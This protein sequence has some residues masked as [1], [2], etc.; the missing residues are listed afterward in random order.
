MTAQMNND[1]SADADEPA[2]GPDAEEHHM[3]VQAKP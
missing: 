3:P 1:P 2:R